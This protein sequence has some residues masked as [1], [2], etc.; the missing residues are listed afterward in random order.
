MCTALVALLK[1]VLHQYVAVR[2]FNSLGLRICY[3]V[4]TEGLALVQ[5]RSECHFFVQGG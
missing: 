2:N 3:Q 4:L 1:Q 5:K